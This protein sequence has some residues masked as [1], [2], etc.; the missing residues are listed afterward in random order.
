MPRN[1]MTARAKKDWAKL[2]Y[3][4][5]AMMQK[6]IC[7]KVGVTPKTFKKWCDDEKW[8]MLKSAEVINKENDLRRIYMQINDLNNAIEQRPEGERHATGAEAD[9]LSKLAGT[10]RNLES[11]TGIA[12][13]VDSFVEFTE[14]LRQN[15]F[16]KAREFNAYFDS[17]IKFKLEK[18]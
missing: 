15:E 14:W 2:L 3:L 7:E 8:E 1:E 13:I 6:E 18:Y 10:A 4:K 9:T 16:D 5:T 12:E 17:F 11:K